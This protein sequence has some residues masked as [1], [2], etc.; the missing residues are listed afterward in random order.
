MGEASSN[1]N[2]MYMCKAYYRQVQPMLLEALPSIRAETALIVV[3]ASDLI[4]PAEAH[5]APLNEAL[6]LPRDVVLVP[7]AAHQCMQE[8]PAVVNEAILRFIE[9]PAA[10]P[11]SEPPLL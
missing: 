8:Q 9:Q 2:P 6:A 4:T 3:G 5:A 1:S 10:P 11:P 7:H